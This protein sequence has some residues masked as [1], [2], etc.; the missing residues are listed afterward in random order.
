MATADGARARRSSGTA[1][2]AEAR[3]LLERAI[4]IGEK[5]QVDAAELAPARTAL[6]SLPR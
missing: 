5:A 6:T 2:P 3:P 4:A 1:Q